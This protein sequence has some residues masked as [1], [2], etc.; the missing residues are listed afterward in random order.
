MNVHNVGRLGVNSYICLS[1]A[2]QFCL[3]LL[4]SNS[5]QYHL[6]IYTSLSLSHERFG[7]FSSTPAQVYPGLECRNV[8][9]EK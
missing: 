3:Y 6:T 4:H 1:F 7:L 9:E 2:M 5:L 8:K